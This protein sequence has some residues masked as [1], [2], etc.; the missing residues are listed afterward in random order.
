MTTLRDDFVY[1]VVDKEKLR[2][3]RVFSNENDA[4]EMKGMSTKLAVVKQKVWHYLE[5][6]DPGY[7]F[8]MEKC[9]PRYTFSTEKCANDDTFSTDFYDDDDDERDNYCLKDW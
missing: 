6:C 7:T 9:A 3:V 4:Y 5:K 8:Y 1:I 2:I